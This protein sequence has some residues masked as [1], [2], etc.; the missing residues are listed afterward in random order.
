MNT[1]MEVRDSGYSVT[2]TTMEKQKLPGKW[3]GTVSFSNEKFDSA[4]DSISD[5]TKRDQLDSLIEDMMGTPTSMELKED[6]SFLAKVPLSGSIQEIAGTWSLSEDKND[7]ATLE[8]VIKQGDKEAK[9]SS[10]LTFVNDE[11]I[12]IAHEPYKNEATKEI[13]FLDFHRVKNKK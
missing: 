11:K 4:R 2:Q 7:S 12:H 10:A 5:K 1:T 3:A 13:F 9:V 8:L 6:G